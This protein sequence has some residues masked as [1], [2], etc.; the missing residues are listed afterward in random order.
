MIDVPEYLSP[1]SIGTFQ[2]CPLKFKYSRIDRLI[3]PPTEATVLGNFVHSTLEGLFALPAEDRTLS[4]ARTVMK[5]VWEQ[6]WGVQA[7]EV[8]N[9]D[10]N[11]LRE[12]RWKAWWCVENYFTL[13]DPWS[14]EPAGIETGLDGNVGKARVKGFID[15]WE[16]NEDG[17][18]VISDYKTGKTPR[19]QWTDDK[20]QQLFIYA[21]L[22]SSETG[23]EIEQLNLL[24]L[25]DGTLLTRPV[26]DE[27]LVQIVETVE[28][29]HDSVAEY[30]EAGE[31]PAVKNKL[32]DWCSYKKICPAWTRN[33]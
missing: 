2:T 7:V 13:E 18:I 16:I 25:K 20:F 4:T 3:D 28:S 19:P 23:N 6:E 10:R 29:V 8:L 17:K 26:T 27:S 24:Y 21:V 5:D 1:S 12:F 14:F 22:L 31:F 30:C 33:G 15:R 32:C 11:A 9:R